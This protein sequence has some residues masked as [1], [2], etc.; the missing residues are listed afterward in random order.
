LPDDPPGRRCQCPLADF[1][2]ELPVLVKSLTIWWFWR[3]H[4]AEPVR[5]LQHSPGLNEFEFLVK[6]LRLVAA[7]GKYRFS[8]LLVLRLCYQRREISVDFGDDSSN[9][10]LL[11][12]H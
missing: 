12:H 10:E 8:V 9:E 5:V 6:L 7:F 2:L 4:N 3:N 11:G 1:I